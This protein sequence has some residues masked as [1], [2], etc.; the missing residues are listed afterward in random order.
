MAEIRHFVAGIAVGL[1]MV[2]LWGAITAPRLPDFE[3]LADCIRLAEGVQS[4]GLEARHKAK[5][6]R[7]V[8]IEVCQRYFKQWASKPRF[9]PYLEY[10]SKRYCPPNHAVWLKNVKY[11]YDGKGSAR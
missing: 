8:C 10:L 6:Y 11:Y 5:G 1:T 2:A 4:Y 7:K 3:R 9:E